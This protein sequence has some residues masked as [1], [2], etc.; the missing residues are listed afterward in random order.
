MMTKIRLHY[1]FITLAL[2][3]GISQAGAQG[4]AFTYQGRLNTNTVPA[5]GSYDFE[6]SLYTNSAGS[7]TQVGGTLTITDVGVT[8][9]LFI[10]PLNFGAVFTNVPTW[11]AISARSNGVGSYTPLTPL[12]PLTPTPYAIT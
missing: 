1:L 12:Q 9:G 6:F 5:N 10:T 4:T 7:G 11:L 8:N 2:F 3:V